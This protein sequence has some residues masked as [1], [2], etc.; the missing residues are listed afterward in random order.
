MDEDEAQGQQYISAIIVAPSA[1]NDSYIY[2][3]IYAGG[4]KITILNYIILYWRTIIEAKSTRTTL[5][6]C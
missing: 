2:A 1:C 4:R 6:S 3:H 5:E